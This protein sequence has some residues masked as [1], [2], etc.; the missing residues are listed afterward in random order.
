MTIDIRGY[1]ASDLDQVA[2]LLNRVLPDTQPHNEPS[3]SITTKQAH[4]DLMFV[5]T[6]G[7]SIVGFI[8][9]GYDGHRGW[10]YQL[11]VD[12]GERRQG[13]GRQL[14]DVAVAALARL[15]CRKVNLQVRQGN[16][17]AIKLYEQSGFTAESRISMGLQL[18]SDDLP[19]G[20]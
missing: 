17:S 20:R 11:A 16:D 19:T 15:G 4:D 18:P 3:R 10:L 12:P 9:A 8:M 2:S 6:T 5:A 1:R 7:S 14:V 13:V